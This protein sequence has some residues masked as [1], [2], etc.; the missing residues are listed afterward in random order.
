MDSRGTFEGRGR[1]ARLAALLLGVAAGVGGCAKFSPDGG[2]LAVQA[3]AM[4][5]RVPAH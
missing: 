2:M 5:S 3:A 4:S 1:R